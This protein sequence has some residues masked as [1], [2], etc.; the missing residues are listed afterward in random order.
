[1]GFCLAPIRFPLPGR[2]WLCF[3]GQMLWRRGVHRNPLPD[4]SLHVGHLGTFIDAR[5]MF[6][7]ALED[8]ENPGRCRLS[9]SAGA[10]GRA[11]DLH[12]V[13]LNIGHLVIDVNNN[14]GRTGRH[15]QR[16]RLNDHRKTGL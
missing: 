7:L 9:C 3:P 15:S 2:E 4:E 11:G 8:G 14:K 5:F 12:T 10:Y 1:M 13:T 16:W 6:D